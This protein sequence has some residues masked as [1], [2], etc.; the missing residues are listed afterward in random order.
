MEYDCIEKVLVK[1][2]NVLNS[3]EGRIV[4]F[5]LLNKGSYSVKKKIGRNTYILENTDSG[6]EMKDE[7]AVRQ[8]KCGERGKGDSDEECCL[9]DTGQCTLCYQPDK[10]EIEISR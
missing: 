6:Q 3:M 9:D 2:C 7:A 10:L 5:L 8:K 4:K 1:A